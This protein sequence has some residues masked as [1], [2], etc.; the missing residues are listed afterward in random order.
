[1]A[2]CLVLPTMLTYAAP[3]L[4]AHGAKGC[5]RM[6]DVVEICLRQTARIFARRWSPSLATESSTRVEGTPT[7]IRHSTC[8]VAAFRK[9]STH[10]SFTS[11][12]PCGTT[13]TPAGVFEA[14]H[15]H[16]VR[17]DRV[18]NG[19]AT[20]IHTPSAEAVQSTLSCYLQ[21]NVWLRSA[22]VVLSVCA[23]GLWSSL[24]DSGCVR[25]RRCSSD[26]HLETWS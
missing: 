16:A 26:I 4:P 24:V 15:L 10:G 17:S 12:S 2:T 9:V 21:K 1:M 3:H 18:E 19:P 6:P 5:I 11:L 8:S 25:D 7:S 23:R 13:I 22:P 20:V 14:F